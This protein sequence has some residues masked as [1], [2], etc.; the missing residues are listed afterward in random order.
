[1]MWFKFILPAI[2]GVL[3]LAL[4]IWFF[5]RNWKD[6]KALLDAIDEPDDDLLHDTLYRVRI[7]GHWVEDDPDDTET[8]GEKT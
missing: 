6:L 8:K 2:A 5:R 7:Q 3:I 4:I 1:M